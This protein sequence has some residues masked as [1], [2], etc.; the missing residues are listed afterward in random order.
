[1]RSTRSLLL[2]LLS[3]SSLATPA[4]CLWKLFD[5]VRTKENGW[6]SKGRTA[7]RKINGVTGNGPVQITVGSRFG[8]SLANIGDLDGDGVQDLLVGAPGE[9][10]SYYNATSNSMGTPELKSGAV[11]VLF[12]TL[13]G[14]VRDSLRIGGSFNGGPRVYEEDA[15]GYSV[16]ALG[17]VDGDGV[18]DVAVGA[19]GVYVSSVY[20]LFM[21]QNG[22]ARAFKLIRGAYRGTAPPPVLDASFPSNFYVPNGPELFYGARFGTALAPL[23]DWDG[24]GVPDL[25]ASTYGISSGENVVYM[26]FLSRDGAVRSFVPISQG[27]NGGPVYGQGVQSFSGFGSSMLVMPDSN[28]DGVPEMVFGAKDLQDEGTSHLHSG[29]LWYCFMKVRLPFRESLSLSLSSLSLLSLSPFLLLPSP[30]LSGEDE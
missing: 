27:V 11:Y 16:S 23:G 29:V 4:T 14:T 18:Q 9:S 30:S 15:F 7:F 6:G 28:G 12:M 20:V 25:C 3:L 8:F 24:D 22:T 13:N 17:D 21:R 1:M 5:F 19:P 10:N 2:L 26:L